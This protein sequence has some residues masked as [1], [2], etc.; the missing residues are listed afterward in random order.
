VSVL[1]EGAQVGHA[2]ERAARREGVLEGEGAERRVPAGRAAVDG[3]PRRVCETLLDEEGGAG[4]D[5]VDVDDAPAAA[6][7]ATVVAAVT[8]GATCLGQRLGLGL[9]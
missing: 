8:G 1:G 5:V 3:E 7:P 6:Q 9:W 2:V 4:A